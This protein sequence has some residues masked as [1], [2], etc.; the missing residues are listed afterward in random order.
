MSSYK[1]VEEMLGKLVTETPIEKATS[2]DPEEIK[3]ENSDIKLSNDKYHLESF[4]ITGTISA[5]NFVK[6]VI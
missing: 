2:F 4:T 5:K 1:K 3:G 6:K